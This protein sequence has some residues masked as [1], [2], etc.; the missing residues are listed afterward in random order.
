[1]K[2]IQHR[3]CETCSKLNL[4]QPVLDSSARIKQM[5]SFVRWHTREDPSRSVDRWVDQSF[6]YFNSSA[7]VKCRLKLN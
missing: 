3:T 2:E 6:V 1:M 5:D 4:F 7:A